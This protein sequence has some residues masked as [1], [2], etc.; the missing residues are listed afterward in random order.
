M[1]NPADAGAALSN[2]NPL[3]HQPTAKT[4]VQTRLLPPPRTPGCPSQHPLTASH[5][6]SGPC[7]WQTGSFL[8]PDYFFHVIA[9]S[10]QYLFFLRMNHIIRGVKSSPKSSK[11]STEGKM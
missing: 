4:S 11:F 8:T 5:P 1:P 7:T 3:R 2:A 9:Q 10:P 6:E